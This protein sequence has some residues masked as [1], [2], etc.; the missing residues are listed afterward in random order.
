M[1]N[2]FFYA[3]KVLIYESVFFSWTQ[4]LVAINNLPFSYGT[5]L[6]VRR[7]ILWLTWSKN[8]VVCSFVSLYQS[9]PWNYSWP[10]FSSFT[11]P[12]V[13]LFIFSPQSAAKTKAAFVFLTCYEASTFWIY[14]IFLQFRKTVVNQMIKLGTINK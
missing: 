4:F 10:A 12:A 14:Y 13:S 5:W 11:R 2:N 8:K 6:E 1:E 3:F 9:Q 7:K